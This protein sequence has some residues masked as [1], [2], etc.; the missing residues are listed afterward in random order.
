MKSCVSSAY[1]WWPT[2]DGDPEG[3]DWL[4]IVLSGVV[5][6]MNRMGPKAEPWGTPQVRGREEERMEEQDTEKDLSDRYDRNQSNAQSE[7]PNHDV[8]RCSRIEWSIVSK[9]A[10]KSSRVRPVTCCR[11]IELM[12]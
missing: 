9:A 4:M 10:D 6:M 11:S 12:R 7:M 2:W 5:Y 1:R 8:R 3:D